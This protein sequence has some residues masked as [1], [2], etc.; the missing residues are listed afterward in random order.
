[1]SGHSFPHVVFPADLRGR[2]AYEIN[3]SKGRVIGA[4]TEST[5]WTVRGGC[6]PEKI[7]ESFLEGEV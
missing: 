6:L 3:S 1:M 4:M 5:E 7:R 2:Q